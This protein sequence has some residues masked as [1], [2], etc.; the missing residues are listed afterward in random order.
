MYST[1][2]TQN[3]EWKNW[4]FDRTRKQVIPLIQELYPDL[5]KKIEKV[6]VYLE[7]N[8]LSQEQEERISD[9]KKIREIKEDIMKK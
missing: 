5:A 4:Y 9:L 8:S 7:N 1:L 3:Q 2:F 6:M